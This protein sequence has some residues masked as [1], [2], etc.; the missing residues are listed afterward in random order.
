[1]GAFSSTTSNISF[2]AVTTN[3]IIA[4]TSNIAADAT[5]CDGDAMADLTVLSANGGNVSWYDNVGLIP[6]VLGLGN[7]F[8]TS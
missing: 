6:P 7:T 2:T 8:T 5:Y 1:M 4:T 3:T